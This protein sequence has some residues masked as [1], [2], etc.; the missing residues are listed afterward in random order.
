MS[1]NR[2]ETLALLG[3]GAAA[4]PSL[5]EA[6]TPVEVRF[7]HGVA[8]GDPLADRA[9]FWTR[10]TPQRPAAHIPVR[11]EIAEDQ[12]FAH[13]VSTTG[14]SADPERD[15]TV[16]VDA[17]G[18]KP[19][20]DYWY[21]FTS[22]GVNSPIGRTRTLPTGHVDSL[23]LAFVTCALYPNGYFNAYDHIAKSETLDAVVELGDY[24]Y[25]Y[26]AGPDD[27]GMENGRK[28]GRIPEPAHDI[29]TLDDYRTRYAQYRRDPDLQAAHARAPWI[30]V[31][32]DHEVANDTWK[33]GAENH[34]EKTEGAFEDRKTAA[35]RA[36]FE[37][38]PIREP[39]P[40]RAAEAIWRSFDFGDLAS[41]TMLETRL[42][43]RSYQLEYTRYGDIAFIVYD[44]TDPKARKPVRDPALAARIKAQATPDGRLPAPYVLGPDVEAIQAYISDPNRQMMGAVQEGWLEDT[45]QASVRSGKP[46]QLIGNEVIMARARMPNVEAVIPPEMLQKALAAMPE[47]KRVEAMKLLHIASFDAPFDLD[48]W[49]G[50]PAARARFD[51]LL[52]RLPGGNPIV[53]SGD[54]HAFWANQLQDIDGKQNLAVEFGTSAIT[55]PSIGEDVGFQLGAVFMQQNREISFCDQLAKGYVR[56]ELTHAQATGT[57]VAVEIDRQ[58]Y[59]ARPLATWTLAPT[60]EPGVGKLQRS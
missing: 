3:V 17:V 54:S 29:V 41:L 6:Q 53:V 45:L 16:K 43:A 14:A 57:M 27:Y 23:A 24:I 15:Y 60:P 52:A 10:V 35:L 25:E 44:A 5:A 46:W 18:L 4:A 38:M 22:N 51:A 59:A 20:R 48:G 12:G 58:P 31:W 28:L 37:W 13:L 21:R 50:Y 56:L 19:G 32:D 30:C 26:G 55:S 33:G 39:K 1:L 9:V 34:N 49:D 2:R 42:T 47:A 7:L 40:G 36:Y 8:S 11:L